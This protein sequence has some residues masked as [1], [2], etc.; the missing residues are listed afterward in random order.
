MIS[1]PNLEMS[2]G[3]KKGLGKK[4]SV[5]H[6]APEGMELPKTEMHASPVTT[7]ARSMF[8]KPVKPLM[9]PSAKPIAS[10]KPTAKPAEPSAKPVETVAKPVEPTAKPL[11]SAKPVEP[12]APKV[13]TVQPKALTAEKPSEDIEDENEDKNEDENQEEEIEEENELAT[14]LDSDLKEMG[15]LILKAETDDLYNTAVPEAYVPATRRGFS[16]FIKATYT[17]FELPA[18]PITIPEG[19]RYYPYQKFVRDY[20]RNEAPYRGILVYHGLGSGKTCTSIAASEA[21]YASAKKK[22]IV[23]TPASLRKNFLKEISFCGFRHFQLNNFW[24]P[25]DPK[26]ATT[27]LFANQILGLSGA[28]LRNAR[29]VW[30]PDFRKPQSE[31]NYSKLDDADRTEIRKQILSIVEWHPKKNPTG[32]IRFLNYNG[33]STKNLIQMACG[34]EKFF[35]NSV[36]VVDEIHNLTRLMQGMIEPYIIPGAKKRKL[37]IEPITP[38]RWK[39][40]ICDEETKLYTRG[41]LFYRLLLDAQNTKIIGLSGTP[42]INFPEELGILANVLHG[43]ITIVEGEIGETGKEIMQK[44]EAVALAHPYVDFV[45]TM[46]AA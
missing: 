18:G 33:L 7:V 46:L 41:Y 4:F 21:L 34:P 39:P 17:T 1:L 14:M 6:V 3:V 19:E 24:V 31:A 12:V 5:G 23:M 36:I 11:A 40:S 9:K 8:A 26:D 25:L 35:D 28:Y 15:D 45:Q 20:M 16:E 38:S 32:R 44:V 29:H 10:A 37:T 43:Y 30:V 22:I 27:T 42:L 2:S 13:L